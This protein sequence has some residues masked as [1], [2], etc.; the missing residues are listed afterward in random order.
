M[1][2]SAHEPNLAQGCPSMSMERTTHRARRGRW[3]LTEVVRQHGGG[4]AAFLDGDGAPAIFN[5]SR[6]VLQLRE[7]RSTVSADSI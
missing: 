7:R 5:G 6:V 4:A 3:D 2:G 1:V